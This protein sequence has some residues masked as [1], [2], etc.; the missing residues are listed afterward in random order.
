MAIDATTGIAAP[1]QTPSIASGNAA[2]TGDKSDSAPPS[3]SELAAQA[4]QQLNTSILQAGLSVSLSSKNDPMALVYKSAIENLNQIL[5]PTLGDNA[6]QTASAQDNS[7]EA[8]AGRIVSLST[9]LFDL[10]KQSYPGVD[11]ST[12]LDRFVK[13]IQ[14][15]IGTGFDEARTILNGMGALTDAIA[16]NIDKT[17]TLVTQG[18]A[19]FAASTKAA[20]IARNA[21]SGQVAGTTAAA[22]NTTT[23]TGTDPVTPAAS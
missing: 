17:Y 12:V 13:V 4:R 5:Q 8:T 11:E 14:S 1:A 10:Y 3:G 19:D 2:A 9:S 23:T 21:A 22:G 6:I 18:L 20:I 16:G 15:G 7:P